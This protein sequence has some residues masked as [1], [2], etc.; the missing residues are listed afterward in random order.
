MVVERVTELPSGPVKRFNTVA[1]IA[2][3]INTFH[4][5][6]IDC[7]AFGASVRPLRKDAKRAP[8]VWLVPAGWVAA[9]AI[10]A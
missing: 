2:R 4:F 8:L 1:R 7:G 10:A 9:N 5:I 6:R 3:F